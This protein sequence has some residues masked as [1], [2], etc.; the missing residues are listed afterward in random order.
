MIARIDTVSGRKKLAPRRSPYWMAISDIEGAYIG[1]RRGPDT[2]VCRLRD[3]EKPGGQQYHALGRFEDHRAAIRVAKDWIASC[4]AGVVDHT[5]TVADA[6]RAYLSNLQQEKGTVAAREARSR[7]QRRVLGRSPEDAR[8]A[9]ARPIETHRMARK[10]L[11]KLR[12]NDVEAWRDELVPAELTGED[13]R[14]SRASA[15]REM[16]ALIAALNHAYKRQMVSTD[17]AWAT[18]GKFRDVQARKHR[19]YV[20][21]NERKALLSAAKDIE[22]GA[23]AHLL[24]G[25]M[26][27]GA[28]PVEL[29]RATVA[30]YDKST[31]TLTL[32]SYKGAAAG[33]REREIPLRA[34]S[35]EHVI[36]KQSSDK[37]PTAPIFTRDD[38]KP[39]GH[40]DWDHLVR[41]A[42][43]A[44][45]LKPLTA[46]DLRHSFITDAL[47][48]GVDPL[49][50]ARVAGTSLQM[51]TQT[52]GKLVEDHA[53]RVFSKIQMT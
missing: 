34:L 18:V 6:C 36:K 48:G 5:A 43:I 51:I 40:S 22:T 12:A 7:L 1:F 50:V 42:R 3:A 23:I 14:K 44:A 13:R 53:L 30:D 9:R 16:A 33:S 4:Q 37:L 39:W 19:R 49:T 2:W 41:A 25:L 10:P 11:A 29:A 28:R 31:G 38:G 15:N 24:E 8:K 20:P 52:Y 27:T 21:L 47:T 35:C 17:M 26:L 32:V 45:N 46:Y